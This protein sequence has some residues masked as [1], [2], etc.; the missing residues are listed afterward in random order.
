LIGVSQYEVDLFSR[1]LDLPA[2]RFIVIPNGSDLPLPDLPAQMDPEQ[3]VLISI[4]RLERYKGHQRVIAALPLV[5]EQFPNLRLLILGSG[6]FETELARLAEQLGVASRVEIRAIPPGERARMSENYRR[7]AGGAAQRT[8]PTV[9][10][11]SPGSGR[12]VLVA[13]TSGLNE[14]RCG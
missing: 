3:P 14:L 13:D 12:L 7:F 10:G 11:I 2:D 6:P 1:I 4:G 9:A 5:L 8:H